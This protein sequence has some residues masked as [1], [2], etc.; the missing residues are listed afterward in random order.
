MY[1]CMSSCWNSKCLFQCMAKHVPFNSWVRKQNLG[2]LVINKYY[3]S[4]NLLTMGTPERL[5]HREHW[6]LSLFCLAVLILPW[7]WQRYILPMRSIYYFT[8][9]RLVIFVPSMKR[10][11]NQKFILQMD[12]NSYRIFIIVLPL[13]YLSGSF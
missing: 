4:N 6:A 7:I 1:I 12:T 3:R 2:D 9:G 11:S 13:P 10:S 5:L 8:F